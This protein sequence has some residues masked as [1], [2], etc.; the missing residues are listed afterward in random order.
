MIG[1]SG[2]EIEVVSFLE[3]N[4]KFFF[5]RKDVKRFFKNYAELSVYLHRLKRKGRIININKSKYY[6]IPVKAFR[7]HWSEH[8]FLIIDEIFDGKNYFIAGY[9]AAHYWKLVDQIP[10]KTEVYCISRPKIKE[11]FHHKIVFKRVRKH[12]I[13]DFVREKIKQHGFNI[14]S[15]E[16]VKQWLKSKR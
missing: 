4:E 5:T 7:G 3:L 1:L 9:S 2:K 11:F 15:K 6:L 13:K 12:R 16:K 10:A 14:A 8:P